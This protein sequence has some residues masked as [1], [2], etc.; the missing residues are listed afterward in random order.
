MEIKTLNLEVVE[1]IRR[2]TKRGEKKYFNFVDE[3]EKILTKHTSTDWNKI[4]INYPE[5]VVFGEVWEQKLGII[6]YHKTVHTFSCM[7]VPNQGLAISRHGH[8]QLVHTTQHG[9]IKK[10]RE[11]YIFYI[12]SSL[13]EMKFCGKDEMHELI[14]NY[15]EP[16]Y[17]ISVKVTGRG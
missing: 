7:Y 2:L 12:P 17:V 8:N 9:D 3:L 6:K 13:V 16:V 11:L 4:P 5:D 15:G 1:D 14:N 10:T